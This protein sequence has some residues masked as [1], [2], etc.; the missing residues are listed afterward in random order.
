MTSD[1]ATDVPTGTAAAIRAR[2]ASVLAGSIEGSG[3]PVFRVDLSRMPVLVD[4]VLRELRRHGSVAAIPPPTLFRR[5]EAGGFDRWVAYAES[6]GFADADEMG[7]AAGDLLA[8]TCAVE[9]STGGGWSYA[10][11]VSGETCRGSAGLAVAS[12][13]MMTSGLFSSRALEPFRADARALAAIGADE[14][15]SGLQVGG[16]NPLAGLGP[17]LDRLR[18]LGHLSAGAPDLFASR[19]DPRPGGLWDAIL[20]RSGDGPVSA[21]GILDLVVAGFGT[22]WST[23]GDAVGDVGSL[24]DGLVPLHAR[25]LVLALSIAEALGWAGREVD[26]IEMLPPAADRI[27]AELMIDSGL[28]TP[29]EPV[30]VLALDSPAVTLWR[31]LSV[32]L[33]DRLVTEL[34][35][36]AGRDGKTMPLPAI[37]EGGILPAARTFAAKVRPHGRPAIAVESDGSVF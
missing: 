23:R 35:R 8:V 24:P 32:A 33:T 14:L 1:G 16:G 29:R 37:V 3:E 19:E 25:A 5:F 13:N 7:R 15:A 18:R 17:R 2:A 4:L 36:N 9:G 27:L 20:A 10:D 12:F 6:I 34:R 11:G 21:P 22:L 30:T 31:A 28:L 26:G